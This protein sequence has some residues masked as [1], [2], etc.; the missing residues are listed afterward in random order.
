MMPLG[1]PR[2]SASGYAVGAD[3]A[4]PPP[5]KV[6]KNKGR[7]RMDNRHAMTAMVSMWPIGGQWTALPRS[8]GA[9]V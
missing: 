7:L 3:S 4:R 2:R 8:L 9:P 1:G 6:R 5:P